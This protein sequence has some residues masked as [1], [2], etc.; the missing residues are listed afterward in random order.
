M[1]RFAVFLDVD[2]VTKEVNRAICDGNVTAGDVRDRDD[3]L[4]RLIFSAIAHA[5]ATG[6]TGAFV[7]NRGQMI[8]VERE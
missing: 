5:S 8:Y 2:P 4:G 3:E 1:I 6:S 7:S